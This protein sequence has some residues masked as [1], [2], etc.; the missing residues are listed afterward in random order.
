M[1]KR[2]KKKVRDMISPRIRLELENSP[3]LKNIT[4]VNNG[5]DTD[6]KDYTRTVFERIARRINQ[7]TT[8]KVIDAPYLVKD[9]ILL[10]QD[11][12]ENLSF[13]FRLKTID[14]FIDHLKNMN[15]QKPYNWISG[16]TLQSY[17]NNGNAKDKK[18]N[19]LLTFL[20]VNLQEWDEW[21][22]FKGTPSN[23]KNNIQHTKYSDNENG[24][25]KLVK[26]YFTGYYYRYF[27]KADNSPVLVKAPF[28]IKEDPH[29][30][31][32]AETKTVGHRYK[33]TYM[34]IRDGALYMEFEN[35]DW[36]E[37]ETYIFNIGFEINPQ[38]ITGVSNTLNRKGQAIAIKNVL[39][40]QSENYDY[41]KSK[42]IEIPYNQSLDTHSEESKL[43]SF[44]K[45]K[46]NNVITTFHCYSMEELSE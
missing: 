42:G 27:Q 11:E 17:W 45:E 37:K 3:L 36:N 24:T 8:Q 6:W 39:V 34:I 14:E 2:P 43:V 18:L 46:G 28:I 40:K 41:K 13:K 38:V 25:L 44:F 26:K 5:V 31:V 35:K 22:S 9:F 29:D 30:I 7:I 10:G 16:K 23:H 12:F 21:K 15:Y 19:V 20:G 1:P 33:S 4:G 32:V